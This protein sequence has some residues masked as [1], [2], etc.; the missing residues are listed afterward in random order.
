MTTTKFG[1]KTTSLRTKQ[2]EHK[3][4]SFIINDY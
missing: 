1:N 3:L 4:D 2:T